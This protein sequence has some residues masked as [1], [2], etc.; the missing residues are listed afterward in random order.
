MHSKGIFHRDLKPQNI[1]LKES[2][3]FDTIKLIDLGLADKFTKEGKYLYNRCGTPGYVAPEVL[4][5]KKYDLKV[6]V[7]S[8]G[9]ITYLVLTGKEPF[10]SNNYDELV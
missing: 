10:S 9:I 5:D 4:Q 6:D 8:I 7:Y 1:M 3:T 2:D